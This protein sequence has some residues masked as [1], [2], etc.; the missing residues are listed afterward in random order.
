MCMFQMCGAHYVCVWFSCVVPVMCVFQMC[1]VHYVCVCFRCVVPTVCVWV[2]M[3]GAHC[4]WGGVQ[5]T[6]DLV[7]ENKSERRE[8]ALPAENLLNYCS[9]FS[10]SAR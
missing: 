8:L 9:R 5:K 4:V 3:C 10:G 6:W 2:Q 7:G 1:G